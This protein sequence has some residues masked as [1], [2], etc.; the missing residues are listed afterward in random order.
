MNNRK[1][2]NRFMLLS[3]VI[4]LMLAVTMSPISGQSADGQ[5]G[6]LTNP[7]NIY[8]GADPWLQYYD[9]TYYLATTTGRSE[10]L[11]SKSETLAGLKA[12]IPQ[13]IYAEIDPS[14]CC[15][16]WAPEFHLLA[17]PNGLRWYYYYSAG[18][19]GT[20]DNQRTHVLESAGI[21]P[22]GPYTYKGRIFDS[23]NDGWAIDS[24][25]LTLGDALYFLFSSWVGG[26]QSLFIAP[27][28]D[29]W[30]ISGV[31]VLI[32]EP[33]YAWERVGLN[34]NEGPV[35]LTNEGQ[36]YIIY[37]ASYCATPDYA[38]GMLTYNGGDPL[39]R[40]S[41]DK[42]PEPVFARADAE[43]VFGPGHN[44]F[45]QS[46]DGT[47]NW[48]VYHANDNDEG[49]CD[50]RRTTR[51]QRFTWNADGTPDFGTPVALGEPIAAPAGDVGIDPVPEFAQLPVYRFR[52]MIYDDSYLRHTDVYVSVAVT[53]DPVVDSQFYVIP[54]LADPAAVSIRS[55]N[56]PSYFLRHEGNS[57]LFAPSDG[58][59]AFAASA[60]WWRR[61]GLANSDW[62]S[63]EAFDQPGRFIGKQFGIM[64]LVAITENSTQIMRE[65]ATFIQEP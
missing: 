31:R 27:M 5:P 59:E 17:G 7:L 34:V 12:A 53:V 22:L 16:M 61:D 25:I 51:V 60:T 47:E 23:T 11:M 54:G 42:H 57:I 19:S 58:T 8:G 6:I 62:I 40:T 63:L 30:T 28:S 32:S 21:D 46:P 20:L 37:S 55:I 13:L 10:L 24:S 64:A 18:S 39:Q 43:G 48:I 49:G 33:E 26:N 14:R 4:L 9:G 1:L 35:A 36:T 3:V 45:F 44:G 29:P 56:L 2:R 65:D 50:D 38:L 41:W 15:N 52:S